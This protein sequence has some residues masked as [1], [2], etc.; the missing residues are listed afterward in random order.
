MYEM[1]DSDKNRIPFHKRT[2]YS[3]NRGEVPAH[4]SAGSEIMRPIEFSERLTSLSTELRKTRKSLQAAKAMSA[5]V[6]SMLMLVLFLQVSQIAAFKFQFYYAAKCKQRFGVDD[7]A[8]YL[9]RWKWTEGAYL[10]DEF[11]CSEMSAYLEW[12]LEDEGYHTIIALGNCPWQPAI[13]H[14]WLLVEVD[15]GK[16]IPVEATQYQIIYPANPYINRYYEYD[17][18]FETIYDALQHNYYEFDW[19]ESYEEF[20]WR[21]KS[22]GY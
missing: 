10:R 14:V 22:S 18:S 2:T 21:E 4:T 19:W 3:Q 13:K 7:L 16:F 5:I 17:H 9:N 8:S 11:D 15:K 12:R 6:T 1:M 20:N